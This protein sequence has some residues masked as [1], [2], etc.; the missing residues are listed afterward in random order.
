[1]LHQI[2]YI[3]AGTGSLFIQAILGSLLAG[4][5]IMRNYIRKVYSKLRPAFSRQLSS[6]EEA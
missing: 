2:A 4:V 3:D 1:M 6:D 5:V